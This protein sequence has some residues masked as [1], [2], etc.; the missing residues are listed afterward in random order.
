LAVPAFLIGT[1]L[2]LFAGYLRALQPHQTFSRAYTLYN[3]GAAATAVL[4]EFVLL[5]L[6]GLQRTILAVAAMNGIVA[7]VLLT[8]FRGVRLQGR[9]S[10]EP[11]RF[12]LPTLSAL[13]IASVASAVFQLLG[14]KL[15]E[16]IVGPFHE[17]FAIVLAVV[18]LGQAVGS[19]IVARWRLSFVQL[20]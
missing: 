10:S 5:R 18:L 17:T 11:A 1:S 16:S 20:M 12:P 15:I 3:L 13:G 9:G 2:P 4:I 19:A 8:A 14:V 6:M 7:V